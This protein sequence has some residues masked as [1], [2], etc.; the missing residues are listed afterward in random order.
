MADHYAVLGV[1]PDA[2]VGDIRRAWI[3]AARRWHPD[4][5]EQ[6]LSEANSAE[7]IQAETVQAEAMM[8]AVNEAWRVLSDTQLRSDYDRA[9]RSSQQRADRQAA[10]AS[11]DRFDTDQFADDRF[12]AGQYPGG[13]PADDTFEEPM[14]VLR[15]KIAVLIVRVLPWFLLTAVIVTIFIV[16]A[17]VSNDRAEREQQVPDPNIPTCVRILGDGNVRYVPC[18]VANDGVLDE[19]VALS[20][21]AACSDP[22]AVPYEVAANR[23]LCIISQDG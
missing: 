11:P 14:F 22:S 19:I 20:P 2:A 17:F 12:E 9:L 18:A 23:R 1:R 5:R 10:A 3:R 21:D 6:E 4:Q 7:T 16:T 15:S 13:S 8:L